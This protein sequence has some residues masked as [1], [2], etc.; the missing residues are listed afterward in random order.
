[1]MTKICSMCQQEKSIVDFPDYRGVKNG[2]A[3]CRPCKRQY[4]R[5]FHANRS[6]E[7]KLLKMQ[8]QYLRLAK[9]KQFIWDYKLQHP[10][11]DCGN[12]D[13]RVL[14]F[15]HIDASTKQD[16]ICRMVN[17]SA[18]IESLLAE[19]EKCVVR[20]SNCHRIRTHAQFGWFNGS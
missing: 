6:A 12:P 14:D 8:K 20:C 13:P 15:D 4:D 10:C 1:M 7:K 19:I 18:S 17:G 2:L 3:K 11:I 16:D 9:N 5:D